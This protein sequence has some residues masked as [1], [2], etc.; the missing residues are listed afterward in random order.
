MPTKNK[1]IKK[2]KIKQKKYNWKRNHRKGRGRVGMRPF[3]QVVSSPSSSTTTGG[4]QTMRPVGQVVSPPSPPSCG[5]KKIQIQI[6]I[7]KEEEGERAREGQRGGER[8]QNTRVPG[9][10][11]I[12]ATQLPIQTGVSAPLLLGGVVLGPYA[13]PCLFRS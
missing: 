1:I 13:G 11:P 7:Q 10:P 3:C 9:V 8:D 5:P 6:Q 12:P 4:C 2:N